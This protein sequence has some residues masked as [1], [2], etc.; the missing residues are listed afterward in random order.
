MRGVQ[1]Q[2]ADIRAA[3]VERGFTQDD[4][5][6]LA[7]VDAKT[8]RK[9]EQG[10]RIDLAPLNRL[11]AALQTDVRRLIVPDAAD[12]ALHERRRNTILAWH[13]AFDAQDGERLLALYHEDAVLRLP[14]EP[15]V[16]F[17]GTFRGKQ[18]IRAAHES[19]WHSVRH[20]PIRLDEIKLLVSDEGVTLTGDKGIYQPNGEL[21]RF[22]CVQVFTFVDDLIA[23]HEVQF[24]TLDFA[25]R[26][27]P[28][29]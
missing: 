9:A 15:N 23:H 27:G 1:V 25:R 20:E 11:A 18:E 10:K 24:D 3:R 21:V 6:R 5:A 2:G 22:P 13:D 17:G 4:L 8:V 28:P 7:G 14:G 12:A 29:Q 19:A 16:P 26:F